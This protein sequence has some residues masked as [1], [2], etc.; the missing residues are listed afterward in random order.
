M[1]K[2]CSDGD[3]DGRDTPH[4]STLAPPI[5][6]RLSCVG[7]THD[8]TTEN[9]QKGGVSCGK[10]QWA[11]KEREAESRR[12]APSTVTVGMSP[13]RTR[14]APT[15]GHPSTTDWLERYGTHVGWHMTLPVDG[16]DSQRG[17]SD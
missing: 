6:F 1:F 17:V 5:D 11:E 7:H 4:N 9:S 14:P 13:L 3:V 2:H 16:C 15:V 8:D 12:A 10:R